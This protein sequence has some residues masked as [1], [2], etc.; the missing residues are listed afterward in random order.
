MKDQKTKP[1]TDQ[2]AELAEIQFT[3]NQ[4]ETIL[5]LAPGTIAADAGL[6]LAYIT[7]TLRGEADVRT[8]IRRMAI[9]GSAPAQKAFLDLISSRKAADQMSQQAEERSR[10]ASGVKRRR[11][12]R[13][14]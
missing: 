2:V 1:L 3:R 13:N 10:K 8:G 5:E 12:G 14:P 7:G 4:V 11:R 6:E 9:Q